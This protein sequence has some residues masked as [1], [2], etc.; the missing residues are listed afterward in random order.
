MHCVPK[1]YYIP[2]TSVTPVTTVYHQEIGRIFRSNYNTDNK[3]IVIVDNDNEKELVANPTKFTYKICQHKNASSIVK[4]FL[5][6]YKKQHS[7]DFNSIQT[8]KNVIHNG[9]YA[10]DDDMVVCQDCLSKRCYSCLCHSKQSTD[11]TFLMKLHLRKTSMENPLFDT[12][13]TQDTNNTFGISKDAKVTTHNGKTIISYKDFD[14]NRLKF[15][16]PVVISDTEDEEDEEEDDNVYKSHVIKHSRPNPCPTIV[17]CK[18]V[19]MNRFKYIPFDKTKDGP[20][21]YAYPQYNYGKPNFVTSRF[22][23]IKDAIPPPNKYWFKY[24]RARS[25]ARIYLDPYQP[26]CVELRNILQKL[27]DYNDNNKS[28]RFIDLLDASGMGGKFSKLYSY[29][30]AIKNKQYND[31]SDDDYEYSKKKQYDDYEYCKLHLLLDYNDKILTKLFVKETEDSTPVHYPVN[32]LADLEQHFKMGSI[33]RLII[34]VDRLWLTKQKI[35]D[36][37]KRYGLKLKISQIEVI[38]PKKPETFKSELLSKYKFIDDPDDPDDSDDKDVYEQMDQE[39][40][41]PDYPDYEDMIE[42]KTDENE[43]QLA[44]TDCSLNNYFD[45]IPEN[46]CQSIYHYAHTFNSIDKSSNYTDNAANT[47]IIKINICSDC[48]NSQ[49]Y[50]D[51]TDEVIIVD[52]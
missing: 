51:C 28:H 18:D 9:V 12:N 13:D 14:V 50:K 29:D 41:Y 4:E 7:D 23:L 47:E 39:D 10:F 5:T 8:F 24:E 16:K 19:D 34:S 25:Y 30:H 11:L 48:Y 36:G 38:P 32:C 1:D 31:D 26:G 20:M 33:V 2:A 42:Q 49:K 52:I 15:S 3:N 44:Y 22:V 46:I 35:I 21:F 17:H 37:K 43:L 40:N 45:N 27:D 6:E